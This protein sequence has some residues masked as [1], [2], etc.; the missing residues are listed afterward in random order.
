MLHKHLDKIDQY[1]Y[2]ELRN[3]KSYNPIV[4]QALYSVLIVLDKPTNPA[5]IKKEF[6]DTLLARLRTVDITK[7]KR[8]Q[9]KLLDQYVHRKDFTPLVLSRHSLAACFF[10]EWIL[11]L[12][13]ELAEHQARQAEGP[14]AADKF[15]SCSEFTKSYQSRVQSSQASARKKPA[16][17]GERKSRIAE[18]DGLLEQPSPSKRRETAKS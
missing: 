2:N 16:Q 11:Q 3:M 5:S 1:M 7:L 17:K 12:H 15:K 9:H 13:K 14:Q 10:S 4:S 18:A 8:E 6:D